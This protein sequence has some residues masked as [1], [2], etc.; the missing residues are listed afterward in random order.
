MCGRYIIF[1][2]EEYQEMK[3]ILK[4]IEKHFKAGIGFE[5]SHEVFP[6]TSVPVI[7]VDGGKALYEMSKWGLPMYNSSKLIINA[8]GETINEKRMFHNL[9]PLV[10]PSNGYFEWHDK[11]KY[12]LK[13]NDL[14]TMYF[15]GLYDKD[16]QSVI[17]TTEASEKISDIHDRMPVI[18][19]KEKAR[20][21]METK[22]YSLILPYLDMIVKKAV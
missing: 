17:I 4:E 10:F 18:L 8:R 19:N 15:A 13:P 3:S 6:G 1:T 14:D 20:S 2:S 12:F 21:W 7:K 9:K 16:N 5:N 11:V 22:D